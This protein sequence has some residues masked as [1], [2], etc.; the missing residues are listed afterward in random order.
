M[1]FPGVFLDGLDIVHGGIQSLGHFAMHFH[2]N[3]A[4][5]E[6][7]LPAAAVEEVLQLLMGDTGQHGR[8]ADLI[9]V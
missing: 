9:A 3:I 5:H 8:I 2:G 6:V 4:F 7:R 1:V